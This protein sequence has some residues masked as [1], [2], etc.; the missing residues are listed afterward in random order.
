[1]KA[2]QA[3]AKA[4]VSDW[5]AVPPAV[6]SHAAPGP[7]QLPTKGAA[8]VADWQPVEAIGGQPSA[9]EGRPKRK[10]WRVADH[11]RTIIAAVLLVCG[12]GW[13]WYLHTHLCGSC[14]VKTAV[15]PQQSI[16]QTQA[17]TGNSA[18]APEQQAKPAAG[19]ATA[20][21]PNP[22]QPVS[23]QQNITPPAAQTVATAPK[24]LPGA[25][26]SL[27]GAY[28]AGNGN[29]PAQAQPSQSA[30]SGVLHY[31]GQPV[32]Y[33]GVVVF[34]NLPRERLKFT[35]DRTAWQLILKPNPDGTKKAILNSLRQGYQTSCDLGWQIV[36]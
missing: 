10:I 7:E 19:S 3:V 22:P 18:S 14:G 9:A 34:D 30:R 29:Q 16:A 28:V 12:G 33:G 15:A 26:K 21:A 27:P 5:S 13:A 2:T 8:P 20:T 17:A 25:R 31:T 24:S 4:A 6:D 23:A 35:F 32:P 36:E 1:V 11:R